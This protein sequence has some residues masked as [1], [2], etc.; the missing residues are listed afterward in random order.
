MHCRLAFVKSDLVNISGNENFSSVRLCYSSWIDWSIFPIPI[1]YFQTINSEWSALRK[2][3]Q[4][5][6]NDLHWWW[7]SNNQYFVIED[8]SVSDLH[9]D[10]TISSLSLLCCTSKVLLCVGLA[11]W[12][13]FRWS[14]LGLA[15]SKVLSV[16]IYWNIISVNIIIHLSS[17]LY[18]LYNCYISYTNV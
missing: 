14:Y 5:K 12:T 10:C 7:W 8:T 17:T 1:L 18:N 16:S 2:V 15:D 3:M 13:F 6:S 11:N 4:E 9:W